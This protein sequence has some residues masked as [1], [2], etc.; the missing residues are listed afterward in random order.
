MSGP[1]IHIDDL[2]FSTEYCQHVETENKT[3]FM[4][5]DFTQET[6]KAKL[7]QWVSQGFPANYLITTLPVKGLLQP[8][9]GF[10]RCSDGTDRSLEEYIQFFLG[11]TIQD[12]I[13]RYQNTL[14][15]ITLSQFTN[16]RNATMAILI[17]K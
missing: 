14:Q 10:Y 13:Q 15:G 1:L 2:Q 7:I 5:L 6:T 17:S 11:I 8:A 12:Y 4:A 3:V 16:P 9:T